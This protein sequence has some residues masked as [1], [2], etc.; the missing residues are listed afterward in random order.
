MKIILQRVSQASV[1]VDGKVVGKID[2]GLL[3]LVGIAHGDD[4]ATVRWM[5]EKTI[6]LRIFED[7]D[8]KMNR[9][10]SDIGGAILAVSQFTLLADCRH[11]R[12]PS[13]TGA[14]VPDIAKAL[15]E[16]Y[17]LQITRSG[18]SVQ[19]GVFGAD[20]QVSLVND[21]PVTIILER[22]PAST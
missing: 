11:G 19:Q 12:R 4:A 22:D 2:R 10:V 6:G 15:Y 5:V 18:I 8:G 21:G 3:A 20:M 17:C 9:S 7:E 1:V 16:D 13:F 14:A